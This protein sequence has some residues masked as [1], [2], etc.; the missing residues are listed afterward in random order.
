[1]QDTKTRFQVHDLLFFLLL[2]VSFYFTRNVLCT[3]LMILFF[4]YTL[5]RQAIT[6]RKLTVPF[7]CVGFLIFILYGAYNIVKHNVINATVSKTM[8]ISLC[9]NLLMI[10]AI[11]LYVRMQQD[12]PKILRILELSIFLTTLVVVLLS[13]GTITQGRLAS[14]TEM[15][16]N[17]LAML[18]VYGFILTL[19]LKQIG[20]MKPT[21]YWTRL[22]LYLIAVLLT[23]SR[24]GLLMIVLAVVVV[25]LTRGSRKIVKTVLISGALCVMLYLLITKIEFLYNIIG[26][27]VENLITLITEGSTEEGSLKSRQTLIEIGMRYVKRKPWTGYGYDCFKLVSGISGSGN[28]GNATF[29]YY[30][31]NNYIELLFGGGIIGTILYYIPIVWLLRKILKSVKKDPCVPYL[32]AILVSKLAIEY[33]YVSY[34]SR[35]DAYLLAVALGC[36][37]I[38]Q[39]ST[40]N[41]ESFQALS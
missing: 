9:W 18:C 15:N 24:K 1:M 2:V 13:L 7:F 32:L 33:A 11:F 16:A 19:Y 5:M 26:V 36:I 17:R 40:K 30:S 34:Y 27:R 22:A 3:G 29:G 8:V 37:L 35:V 6:G 21:L 10:Y 12:I 20:K 23:G 25:N 14:S 31:H 28:T 39:K 38:V 4:G 41:E